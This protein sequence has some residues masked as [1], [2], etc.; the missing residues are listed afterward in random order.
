MRKMMLVAAAMLLSMGVKAQSE[1]GSWS[2]QPKLGINLATMT[3]DEGADTRVALVGGAEFEYQSSKQFSLSFG[4]LYSQQ[5]CKAS[6]NGLTGTIKMD[7]VNIPVLANFY[8]A[9]GFALKVGIQPGI[10]VNDKVK[11]SYGG[12]SAEIGIK[13]SFR[14]IGI[15]ADVKSFVLAVPLG[16]SYEFSNILL[17]AR[18]NIG[19]SKAISAEG[20]S[21]KHNVFQLT[22]GYK[23][24]L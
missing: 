12:A 18:Y 21:T 20:E 10:L 16:L 7:Y 15:D 5:G 1:V 13:E 17:D 3:D 23:F 8:V 24:S 14:D 22:V 9:K 6:S 11:V 4:A 2:F 19:V